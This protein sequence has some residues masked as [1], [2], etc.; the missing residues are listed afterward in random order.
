MSFNVIYRTDFVSDAGKSYRLEMIPS[1]T[2][3]LSSPAP[4]DF[5]PDVFLR[6]CIVSAE[7]DK[8]PIGMV[9]VGLMKLK[10]NASALTTAERGVIFAG[11]FQPTDVSSKVIVGGDTPTTLTL[12]NFA[13]W[14][15]AGDASN[16]NVLRTE[17]ALDNGYSV[18]HILIEV[19]QTGTPKVYQYNR[20]SV[21]EIVDQNGNSQGF[22]TMTV[23]QSF[24]VSTVNTIQQE[25]NIGNLW[26]LT[27]L[28]DSQI[29]FEGVQKRSPA[30]K[31][32]LKSDADMVIEIELMHIVRAVLE[33]VS[34]QFVLSM[35]QITRQNSITLGTVKFGDRQNLYALATLTAIQTALASEMQK[36]YRDISR[37]ATATCTVQGI[38]QMLAL[39]SGI[40]VVVGVYHE[41]ARSVIPADMNGFDFCARLAENFFAKCVPV[42]S[43]GSVGIRFLPILD[44]VGST[45]S[46]VSF[47][48]IVGDQE[49]LIGEDTIRGVAVTLAGQDTMEIQS[50]NYGSKRE[51]DFLVRTIWSDAVTAD[52]PDGVLTAYLQVSGSTNAMSVK[53]KSSPVQSITA[54]AHTWSGAL[55]EMATARRAHAEQ[56][57][58]A[59]VLQKAYLQF[60][61]KRKARVQEQE[62]VARSG[63]F[64]HDVGTVCAVS[65]IN[66]IAQD[67]TTGVVVS[68]E[69]DIVKEIVKTR[70]Y[71]FDPS[72]LT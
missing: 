32:T 10:L 12:T 66:D 45:A 47:A 27:R 65:A 18:E 31:A 46:A 16:F 61:G 58:L 44:S 25:R 57:S 62:I 59:W 37:N 48:E 33:Q 43:S 63:Y 55:A 34:M 50:A 11:A 26:R 5:A 70:M 72:S 1:F 9:S 23:V 38:D 52:P 3:P 24:T 13:G 20:F 51:G 56:T 4:V 30:V 67:A 68:A 29:M 21:Y 54:N 22:Q 40:S 53:I 8:L 36:A 17:E 64:A 69:H 15:N 60:F 71:C 49:V 41:T 6:E 35:V 7:F 28:S 14:V 2:S 39:D 42:V 19:K